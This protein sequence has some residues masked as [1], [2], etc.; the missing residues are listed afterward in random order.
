MRLSVLVS[1][2]GMSLLGARPCRCV[3]CR[4]V[5]CR[6]VQCRCV[7]CR[8]PSVPLRRATT[9]WAVLLISP[10]VRRLP[11][12]PDHALLTPALTAG[13]A[14]S[15]TRRQDACATQCA[16]EQEFCTFREAPACQKVCNVST[17]RR[18]CGKKAR[19][20]EAI[21][22]VTSR[23]EGVGSDMNRMLHPLLLPGTSKKTGSGQG[24]TPGRDIQRLGGM[25]QLSSRSWQRL[26]GRDTQ[27]RHRPSGRWLPLDWRRSRGRHDQLARER[28]HVSS[29]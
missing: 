16:F 26:R 25:P 23:P 2:A 24:L 6:W 3:Q 19:C 22:D 10:P 1:V 15:P 12:W 18:A 20:S 14:A 29:P 7:P 17:M 9:R 27:G 4:W 28:P 5:Q 8:R 11:H 21:P 13:V